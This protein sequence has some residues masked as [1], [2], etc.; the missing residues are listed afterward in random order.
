MKTSGTASSEPAHLGHCLR[1]SIH[2]AISPDHVAGVKLHGAVLLLTVAPLG[3]HRDR[4]VETG[5]ACAEI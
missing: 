3:R 4:H 5:A 1:G 2:K